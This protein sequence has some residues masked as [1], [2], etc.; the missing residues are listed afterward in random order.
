MSVF[1]LLMWLL[2][3]HS[4]LYWVELVL[5]CAEE[6]HCFPVTHRWLLFSSFSMF[7]HFALLRTCQFSEENF[8]FLLLV[9]WLY[10]WSRCPAVSGHKVYKT[11]FTSIKLFIGHLSVSRRA[12]RLLCLFNLWRDHPLG[13]LCAGLGSGS[14]YCGF[15]DLVFQ[16]RLTSLF[17]SLL[18]PPSY[19]KIH[20]SIK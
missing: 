1:C 20:H 10:C 16:S 2:A 6:E 14:G 8:F 5:Y 12:Q 4:V 11:G 13:F 19:P 15:W 17:S 18:P 3:T 7:H 9:S